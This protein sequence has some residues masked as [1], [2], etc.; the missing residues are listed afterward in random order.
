MSRIFAVKKDFAF[1]STENDVQILERLKKI[2]DTRKPVGFYDYPNH[3]LFVGTIDGASFRLRPMNFRRNAALP[4]L[5]GTIVSEKGVTKVRLSIR[6]ND[7]L[8]VILIIGAVI[9]TNILELSRYGRLNLIV[10][11]P[12]VIIMLILLIPYNKQSAIAVEHFQ[13]ALQLTLVDR[14][15]HK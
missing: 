4:R 5:V 2:C 6:L 10:L 1:Q 12:A 7:Y 13:R 9:G 8:P 3:I 11:I 14:A 15:A